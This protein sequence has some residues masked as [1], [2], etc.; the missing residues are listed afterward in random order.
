M[1]QVLGRAL[2]RLG[3]AMLGADG[4]SEALGDLAVRERFPVDRDTATVFVHRIVRA[5]RLMIRS[6]V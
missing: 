5:G 1:K 3:A 4:A 6:G 2:R